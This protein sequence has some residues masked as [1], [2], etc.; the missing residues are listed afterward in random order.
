M[1]LLRAWG[2]E[3]S[4]FNRDFIVDL[5]EAVWGGGGGADAIAGTEL[6]L[7]VSAADDTSDGGL[8][9]KGACVTTD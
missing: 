9:F 1:T 7:A 3:G 2:S 6:G 8:E 5:L 4:S